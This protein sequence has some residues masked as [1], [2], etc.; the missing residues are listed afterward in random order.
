VSR[1]YKIHDQEDLHFLTYTV[2]GLV[3]ALSRPQYKDIV[4]E[5]LAYSQK[6]KGLQLFALCILS[7]HVH[8]I[9]KAATGQ[10][11]EDI[12]RDLKKFTAKALVKAIDPNGTSCQRCHAG[13]D[14]AFQK[15][16]IPNRWDSGPN[17][18]DSPI[19][20]C[21]SPVQKVICHYP[22]HQ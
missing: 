13:L 19:L 7:D 8:L 15:H 12:M 14:P 16:A 6:E 17:T 10:K 9:A 22:G 4:V 18:P 21:H 3:D 5:S 2:V 20:Q 11:L 1:K